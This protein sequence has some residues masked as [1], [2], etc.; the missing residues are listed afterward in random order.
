MKQ[1]N[2]AIKFLM[3]QYRAIFKNANIAMVAA[4]AAAALAAGSANAATTDGN[5]EHDEWAKA[6]E[7]GKGTIEITGV[8]SDQGAS[9]KFQN[10]KVEVTTGQQKLTLTSGQKLVLS[11]NTSAPEANLISASGDGIS[12]N[13]AGGGDLEVKSVQSKKDELRGLTFAAFDSGSLTA[14]FNNVNVQSVFDISTKGENSSVTLTA[15]NIVI[16]D[17]KFVEDADNNETHGRAVIY[18]GTSGKLQ[19]DGS[20]A[21]TLGNEGT[22]I[23][24][25]KDGKL[26]PS[27]NKGGTTVNA[28]QVNV[29]GGIISVGSAVADGKTKYNAS[30]T[31]IN[32]GWFSV[33]QNAALTVTADTIDLNGTSVMDLGSDVVVEAGTITVAP[34]AVLAASD[35]AG[36]ISL[37]KDG[38]ADDT[39]VLKLGSATLKQYL[40]AKDANDKALK[41]LDENKQ[42]KAEG[43][44]RF[45]AAVSG[46]ITL[47]SGGTLELTDTENLDVAH[48]DIFKFATSSTDGKIYVSGAG[49]LKGQNLTVSKA[50]TDAGALEVAA[51]SLT[52]GSAEFD[53]K[54]ALGVGNFWA[55]NVTLVN[56][57]NAKEFVLQ[58]T[59]QLENAAEGTIKGNVNVK[60]NKAKI[61]ILAGSNIKALNDLVITSGSV[62]IASDATL[63][64]A[65]KLVTTATDGTITLED[66]NLDASKASAYE[67]GA[68]TIKMKGASTLTLDG[69]KWFSTVNEGTDLVKFKDKVAGDAVSGNNIA[70]LKLT[71]IQSM[72]MEQF[73]EL[74]K[75]TKFTGLFEG[76][77]VSTNNPAEP[78]LGLGAVETGTP[79][80][81]YHG[82]QVTVTE[83]I[84]DKTYNVGSVE[85]NGAGSTLDLESTNGSNLTLTNAGANSNANN[86]F[87]QKKGSKVAAGVTLSGDKTVLSLQGAGNIGAIDAKTD[88]HG[89]FVVG[90]FDGSK[91]GNVVVKGNIGETQALNVVQASNNSTMTVEGTIVKTNELHV[92]PGAEIVAGKAGI[93]VGASGDDVTILG[94]ITA[95]S[96]TFSA[97]D[98]HQLIAG[99]ATLDLGTLIGASGTTIQVGDDA[100]G[101]LGATVLVGSLDLQNG[102]IFVDPAYGD[103]ASL[104]IADSLSGV[105]TPSD[106]DAG[107]LNGNAI[108]GN[109]AALGIGFASVAELKA[110]IGTYL[111][112]DESFTATP[113]A[114]KNQLANALV[115][116][117]NVTVGDGKGITLQK[118]AT[119]STQV[120]PNT[121]DL[122][123]GTGLIVTDNAFA[124]GTD[125]SKTGPAIKFNNND[126][127]VTAAAGSSVVLVGDFTAADKGLV[128]F[129][130]NSGGATV[131]GNPKV[132]AAGGLLSGSLA[133]NGSIASLAID[134]VAEKA[135][136]SEVSAPVGQ[137][138]V[139]FANGKFDGST[140][141]GYDFLTKA[142]SN[143]QFKAVDAAAHAAT[144][145]GAQ[146]AA[147][148]SV[149]TMADAMFG[150]VGAVGVEAASI[151]AT[152][153]QANGGVWLTPMYKSMD[154]DG[155]NA[156]GASYGSDVDAAGVAFGADTVNGNMR[157][158]AVFNIGSGDAEGKGNG[159]GLKDEFDY[160]GFGIYSAMGFGNLALVGDASLTVISHDVEGLGLRGKA[161]TTAVTMGLTGQYTVSTPMVDVTPHLGARFIRLNTDSYDLV[162]ADGAIATT[163]FDVQNVFSVPLGVTLSKGFTTGGWTL[164]P[165]ADLTITF[166]GGDTE[167]KSSTTFTGIKAI[168]M[169][170]EVL[171]EVTYGLT[172]GLGAQYGAFGTSFGINYTGS[173]NTDSFGV[174]AQCR[175]MF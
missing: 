93:T 97:T 63:T 146:Q 113:D 42:F 116:N 6:L 135:I 121:I 65:G 78:S 114:S 167:A 66:G 137:L 28:A 152:G 39:A 12:L 155:F 165:S 123:A 22:V 82:T 124:K 94:D 64:V 9:G 48:T 43:D 163:D 85:L 86:N 103:K 128:I 117:K 70:T 88:K 59:L 95:K 50:L 55:E 18:L 61:E 90:S 173:E 101:G 89:A 158:G 119:T 73:Q 31:T 40:T 62:G 33:K 153:S 118:G 68:N 129:D 106:T 2:N 102:T 144:Y 74:K 133:V 148:V 24:I 156:Q 147:V 76:F 36:N 115:V 110:V 38:A 3:A 16:G 126:G 166:N 10:L 151:S 120:T 130:D 7:D 57:K 108:V 4:M 141:S 29:N 34:T 75:D 161:D 105:S 69:S 15:K 162:G 99:G 44:A 131:S 164:A 67:L 14:D 80:S 134:P 125:G 149:T 71:G 45:S 54:K 157:F 160:Y 170:T 84:A 91:T 171:D 32:D 30:K 11:D 169:N 150:R 140:G 13:I 154:S 1:T 23:T 27:G 87:V 5:L 122:G 109:N 41:Y 17:G 46:S 81:V 8:A 79:E 104:V 72:T 60:G 142:I 58:D 172:L 100:E 96:L 19:T 143:K 98:S 20:G 168:N 174:N 159:N 35:A 51:K 112:A 138:F 145:A 56:N 132:V 136:R 47:K 26:R 139:D 37:G 83:K 53:G 107:T 92:M 111:D 25:H 175:Y 52:L 21:A 49:T 77:T 127:K